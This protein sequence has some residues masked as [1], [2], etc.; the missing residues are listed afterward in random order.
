MNC[1]CGGQIIDADNELVCSSCGVVS[2]YD[3]QM[4][5]TANT[6]INHFEY[7]MMPT[8][9]GK[10]SV[11]YRGNAVRTDTTK[12]L[13]RYNKWT[14]TYNRSIPIAMTQLSGLRTNLGMTDACAEYAAYMLRRVISSGFLVGRVVPHVTAAVALLA[15]RKHQVHRTIN[16]I[17]TASGVK[18]RDV[19]RT[20]TQIKEMFDEDV[21]LPDPIS[22]ISRIGEQVGITEATRRA[23]QK[24]LGSMNQVDTAGKDPMGLAAGVLYL[25]CVQRGESV[26]RRDI[27]K[28]AGVAETTLSNRYNKLIETV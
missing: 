2:G 11:D 13:Q 7:D 21:P 22:Y 17:V 5:E 6:H 8:T 23:A 10:R 9:I 24:I 14:Q 26:L 3:E 1:V 19:Y 16:D 28:A 4:P 25:S 15:C 27:A 20:F 12:R 18:K